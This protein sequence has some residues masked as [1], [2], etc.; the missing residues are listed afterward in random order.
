MKAS[1]GKTRQGKAGQAGEG[2]ARQAKASLAE[3]WPREYKAR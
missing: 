2:K 3:G 1:P